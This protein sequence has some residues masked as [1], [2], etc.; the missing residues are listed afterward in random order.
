MRAGNKQV[1]A[2]LTQLGPAPA[3]ALG[4]ITAISSI[5][6]RTAL[7]PLLGGEER[8][9]AMFPALLLASFYGGA[10]GGVACLV[11]SIVGAWFFFVGVPQSFA[12]DL[13]E[14][15][16]LLGL[17]LSGGAIVAGT[18]AIRRLLQ[19]LEEANEAERLLARELQHRVKNN[20]SVVEAL[21]R[22]SARGTDDL[23]VFLE[24]FM[25][26]MRSLS[27]A[28][29]LLSRG[30][31]EVVEVEEVVSAVLA[32]FEAPRR[33]SWSGDSLRLN[34]QQAV[35]LALCLHE[36]ATNSVKYGALSG[37]DGVVRIAWSKLEPTRARIGWEE[38]GGPPVHEPQ[39]IGSGLRLLR[40]GVEPGLP[41][42]LAY[43]LDGLKWSA[44]FHP[45]G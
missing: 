13:Y 11:V 4:V 40:R 38:S 44:R 12:I 24:R 6:L 34:S 31:A 32:P 23:A 7:T 30:D 35:A 16:G 8:F 1:A 15:A 43:A 20:L 39:R 3:L 37:E 9:V 42:E 22:T 17:F 36:L 2:A 27:A 5:G 26:R 28:H 19:G 10:T 41:A 29:V 45:S 18:V 25:G 33:L 21:A 14:A